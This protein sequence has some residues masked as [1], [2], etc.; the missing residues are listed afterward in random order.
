MQHR[1]YA[2]GASAISGAGAGGPTGAAGGASARGASDRGAAA[3][4]GE[5]PAGVPSIVGPATVV[6]AN[7]QGAGLYFD[8]ED[9]ACRASVG[10]LYAAL[11][12]AWQRA[13]E[14]THQRGCCEAG[15]LLEPPPPP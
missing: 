9:A 3:G 6:W 14:S 4:L 12:Q 5:A 15:P 13:P 10:S 11:Q 8:R 1:P 2:L 7:R